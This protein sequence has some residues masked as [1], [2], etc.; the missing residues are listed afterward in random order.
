MKQNNKII[1][2]P[3]TKKTWTDWVTLFGKRGACGGCWCM[4]WRL[5]RKEFEASKGLKNMRAMEALVKRGEFIGLIAYKNRIPVGWCAVAPREKFIR[6]EYSRVL[7]RIDDAPVWSIPCFFIAKSERRKGLSGEILN[8]VIEFC[9][10]KKIKILEA[11]PIRP[12]STNIPAPFAYTGILSTFLKSGFRISKKW[13]GA[14][15]IVRLSL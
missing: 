13:S 4:W 9:G 14:R 15:P 6:L 10:K 11:Y 5:K 1:L 7:K 2:K 3:L 8:G 12:Y